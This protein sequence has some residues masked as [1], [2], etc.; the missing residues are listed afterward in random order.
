M[1]SFSNLCLNEFLLKCSYIMKNAIV[2]FLIFKDFILEIQIISAYQLSM[3]IQ[4]SA[5]LRAKNKYFKETY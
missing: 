5:Y 4:R 2:F 3:V 1:L